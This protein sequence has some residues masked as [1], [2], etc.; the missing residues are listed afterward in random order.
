MSFRR[1]LFTLGGT[2][3]RGFFPAILLAVCSLLTGFLFFLLAV[4]LMPPGRGGA[5]AVIVLDENLPDREL[6]GLLHEGPV[7]SESSQWV[8]LDGFSG[9][10]RI[11]LDEYPDRVFSFDPRND[12]YAERL[13]AFFVRDGK[14][15]LYVPLGRESGAAGRL[16]K[17]L[18]ASLGDL[19]FQLEWIGGERP[20]WRYFFLMVLAGAGVLWCTRRFVLAPCIPVLAGFSPAGIPGL[21]LAAF[22][23]GL[24]GLLLAPCGEYF[25]SLRYKKNS[26]GI[27]GRARR[28]SLGMGLLKSRLLLAPVFAAALVGC[29]LFG[30]VHPLLAL[31]GSAG[32]MGV[33]LFA[34][35]VFSRRGEGQ[36]HV[37]FSPVAIRRVP[38]LSPDFSRFMLPYALAALLA[39]PLS[40]VFPGPGGIGGAVSL[41]S[42]P[43]PLTEAEYR[44]H[45]AF[46]ASFSLRPLGK[47][48]PDSPAMYLKELGE[49]SYFRYARGDDG[50]IAGKSAN[51]AGG[52]VDLGAVPPFPL[53]DLM[54]ALE[55]GRKNAAGAPLPGELAVVLAVLLASL[56][57]FGG[58]RRG[59]KRGKNRLSCKEK[60]IA[61]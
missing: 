18:A 44:S 37:R 25:M 15:F 24:G 21:V 41:G 26:P 4:F 51:R 2:V 27:G 1:P 56:P 53:G 8:F 60:G 13:R 57:A 58:I 47:E 32:F 5:Y 6:R 46:Q 12:G 22:L 17:R 33:Y 50:L 20:V 31:G 48:P 61:A 16:E 55:P 59:D 40:L 11:P 42:A 38:A 52:S 9:L 19:P 49:P 29:S 7:I 30:G 54:A 23:M 43:P 39:I 3:Y 14:R 35:R 45:A 28:P 36:N 10:Q 34:H